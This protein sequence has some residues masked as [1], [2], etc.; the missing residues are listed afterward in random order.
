MDD[1]TL[2]FRPQAWSRLS[3]ISMEPA[4]S[5]KV[6][7]IFVLLVFSGRRWVLKA[8]GLLDMR[9]NYV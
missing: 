5:Q 1:H 8:E 4:Q 3:A 6:S 7:N 2:D 9:W